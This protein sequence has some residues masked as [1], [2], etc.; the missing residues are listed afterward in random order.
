MGIAQ[1]LL[2]LKDSSWL[3]FSI[4][5]RPVCSCAGGGYDPQLVYTKALRRCV[6]IVY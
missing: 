3:S 1:L 4:Y 6:H 2:V 5:H